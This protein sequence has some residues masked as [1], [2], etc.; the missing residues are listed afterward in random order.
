MILKRY[1]N[2]IETELARILDDTELAPILEKS[3]RYAL[4]NGGKRIRPS[5]TLAI[6]EMLGGDAEQALPFACALEMIHCYS[7]VHDDLPAMD[8]DAFRR[9]KPSVHKQFGEGNA[10]LAGDGLLTAAALVL[11]RQS[12]YDSAKS[13][14]MHAA[15]EM[16]S[17][18]SYDLN[19]I[20]RTEEQLELLNR[21]KTGA[22]F[23]AAFCTGAHLSGRSDLADRFWET[24]QDVGLLFQ[25][26]DDILDAQNDYCEHKFTY[27]TFYGENVT[28]SLIREI[29]ERILAVL[30]QFNNELS[31]EISALIKEISGRTQ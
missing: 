20:D 22:L 26:T 17:G 24:G 7:L 15:L 14:I 25:M 10:I 9:G 6:C 16:A 31:N 13:I 23:S 18:Q 1:H 8:D 30:S 21:Q 11:C 28:H 4:L 29:E 27:V 2:R 3:M 12:G 5:L 19:E